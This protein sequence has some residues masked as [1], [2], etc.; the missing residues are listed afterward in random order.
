MTLDKALKTVRLTME[1]KLPNKTNLRMISNMVRLMVVYDID[2]NEYHVGYY[3]YPDCY[4]IDE[5]GNEYNSEGK[6]IKY[7]NI[8]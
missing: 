4:E 8:E 6:L 7:N 1:K 2:E 5:D 3:C